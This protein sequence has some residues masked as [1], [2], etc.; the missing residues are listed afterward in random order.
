LGLEEL[1]PRRLLS[2]Y[3]FDFGT[4]TSPVAKG[5]TGV[6]LVAYTPQQ[7]YG[8]AS[9]TGLSAVNEATGQALTGDFHTGADGTFLVDLPNGSYDVMP[10]LGDALAAHTVNLWAQGATLATNL[11]SAAGQYIHPTYR[12]T[13]TTGQLQ[14]RIQ[15]AAGSSFA[16]DGLDI[17]PGSGLFE[18]MSWAQMT[19]RP[20]ADISLPGVAGAEIHLSWAMPVG[21]RWDRPGHR[22][23][24][25]PEPRRA[26]LQPLRAGERQRGCVLRRQRWRHVRNGAVAQRRHGGRHRPGGG[27]QPGRQQLLPRGPD[28]RRRHGLLLGHRRRA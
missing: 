4:A 15:G 23:R 7:G 17:N 11:T 21:D 6:P 20:N 13:V 27:H 22:P 14:L 9:L 5:Y 16:L 28:Q 3:H 25:G 12:V 24:P 1:E 2:S 8:W 18:H 19:S 10:S 26:G